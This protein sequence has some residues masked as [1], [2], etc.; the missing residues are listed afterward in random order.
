MNYI[1]LVKQVPDIT[2]IPEEAWDREKGTLKRGVLDTVFNPL[3]L[4]ALTFAC[5]MKS[6]D[7]SSRVLCLTMGP[8]Q[9]RELLEDCMARGADEGVL[10]TDMK[11]AGADTPATAYALACAIRKIAKDIFKGQDYVIVTGMQSVDG[12]TAQVPPQVAEELG[13]EQIAYAQSFDFVKGA[14]QVK[15]IGPLGVETIVPKHYP[16]LITVIQCMDPVY[17]SFNRVRSIEATS[18]HVWNAEAV[19]AD[20]DLIGSKG[21]RTWVTQI[22]SVSSQRAKP[23][24]YALSLDELLDRI[25]HDFKHGSAREDKAVTPYVLGD[26]TPSLNGEVWVYAEQEKGAL[27]S[28]SLEL[29][30]KA[31]ELATALKQ[32]VAAVIVGD[33]VKYLTPA[34]FAAGADKVYMAEHSLLKDFLPCPFKKVIA[35]MVLEYRP[36]IMLFG[37]SPL[38]RELAPRIAYAI[39]AGLTADCTGLEIADYEKGSVRQ[40]AI[41]KQTRPALG[42]NIMAT[43]ITKDSPFQL[44]TVRPGVFK[45]P[46]P[47]ASRKGEVV[48]VAAHLDDKDCAT[49]IVWSEPAF[50]KVHLDQAEV[51]VSGGR[52]MGSKANFEKYLTPLADALSVWLKVKVEIAGSRMAVEDGFIGHARQVGQTGQTVSPKLY[53]AVAISGAVQHITGMQG[54]GTIFSINKDPHARIYS[55]SDHG[56]AADLEEVIPQLIKAIHKRQGAA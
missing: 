2:R 51:I 49:K 17:R 48:R 45:A 27:A 4:Q 23:C 37:A 22:A 39:S 42:G 47:D 26:K 43:I 5:R 31:R 20:K 34:L 25:E 52:G 36:Q 24:A 11:F 16:V 12:D 46:V 55:Y 6:H 13:M 19:A 7:K 53:V 15:R 40:I 32:K 1:V 18:I 9:A 35:A 29:L 54:S 14:L 33:N 50:T 3:D 41:L 30:G 38:G 21:S 44:A 8:N 56:L 28:V 10:L